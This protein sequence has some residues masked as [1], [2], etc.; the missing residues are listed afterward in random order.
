MY[1]STSSS[2]QRIN[3]CDQSK[4][5]WATDQNGLL[6]YSIENFTLCDIMHSSHNV[7]F[8]SQTKNVAL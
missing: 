8:S 2:F 6:W 1:Y 7:H 4:S 5:F 3:N